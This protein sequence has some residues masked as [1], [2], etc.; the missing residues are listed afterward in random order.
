LF[1]FKSDANFVIY[2]PVVRDSLE[3]QS[4]TLSQ[5][6]MPRSTWS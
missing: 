6:R 4:S 2:P 1:F 3:Q 5:S